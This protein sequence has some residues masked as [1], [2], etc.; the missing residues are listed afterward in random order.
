MTS[1][2]TLILQEFNNITSRFQI[3]IIHTIRIIS[4]SELLD[5]LKSVYEDEIMCKSL[6]LQINELRSVFSFT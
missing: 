1:Y 6:R 5:K 2:P 4:P 3:N